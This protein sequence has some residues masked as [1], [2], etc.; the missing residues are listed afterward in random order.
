MYQSSVIFWLISHSHTRFVCNAM[1]DA[2][3]HY[4]KFDI[5]Y[6]SGNF[7]IILLCNRSTSSHRPTDSIQFQ[8]FD[9]KWNQDW[10]PLS[11]LIDVC[12]V[13]ELCFISFSLFRFAWRARLADDS[14]ANKR[15]DE[16]TSINPIKCVL[17]HWECRFVADQ[18]KTEFRF[19]PTNSVEIYPNGSLSIQQKCKY[20]IEHTPTGFLFVVAAARTLA[21]WKK[22]VVDKHRKSG[23][24]CRI[25]VFRQ[26]T[27]NI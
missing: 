20:I 5:N 24:Y 3:F 27:L 15:K 9:G 26:P 1:L 8:Q 7:L 13:W 19:H 14:M 16:F 21:A 18:T 17:V 11:W 4:Y 2:R 25:A 22:T 12:D 10:L 23:A 6:R